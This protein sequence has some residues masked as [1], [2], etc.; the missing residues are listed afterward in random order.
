MTF[1]GHFWTL[2]RERPD[3]SPL[4]FKQRY[5]G[6]FSE[7]G[8]TILGAWEICFE[9]EDWQKDFDLNYRRIH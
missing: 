4:D 1:D 9:G 6:K 7:D 2:T 3:F 8:R 5:T